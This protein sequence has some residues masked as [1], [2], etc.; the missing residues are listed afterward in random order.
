MT[1]ILITGGLGFLGQ[2]V[3]KTLLEAYPDSSV[4]IL[5]RSNSEF[6]LSELNNSR[7]RIIA[8]INIAEKQSIE[9]YFENVDYVIHIAAMISFWHKDK[10]KMDEINISGT[11]NIVEMCLKYGIKRLVHISSTA[12][13][14]GSQ[15]RNA[16]ADETNGYDWKGKSKYDY[17]LSKFYAEQ[18]VAKGV[19]AGLD[20]VIANPCTVIGYGDTKFFP[21]VNAALKNIP[22][23]LSGGSHMID[24]RDLAKGIVLLLTNGKTGERYLL[25]SEY[26]TQQEIMIALANI[27][28]VKPPVLVI[29]SQML[30]L[31]IPILMLTD[32][33][34][35]KR[36]K[37][38]S[39]IVK[40]GL[41]TSY[42]TNL[43]AHNDLMWK[44]EYSLKESLQETIRYYKKVHK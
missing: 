9:N 1:K 6:F 3:A 26:H 25:T 30:I 40:N 22:F 37:L 18:E 17:G 23:C 14:R 15:T 33:L 12:V 19:K 13:I 44:P 11:K 24:V 39:T 29:S 5:A 7:V 31:A 38:T 41:T 8:N 2:H 20:A 35:H 21:V 32:L 10:H 16:P 27:L 36:P 42:Y 43:K 28:N 34:A 4:V